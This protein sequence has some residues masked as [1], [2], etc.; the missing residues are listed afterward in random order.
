MLSVFKK[1]PY[2]TNQLKAEKSKLIFMGLVLF[3]Q[4]IMA[5][6]LPLPIRFVLDR[7]LVPSHEQDA[8]QLEY[9]YIMAGLMLLMTLIVVVL[10][11]YEEIL[12]S[13]AI[14]SL[15]NRVR[16]DLF[17][18]LLSRQQSYI[19]SKR[20]IDL[21]GR[22]SGDVA[23]L[24]IPIA[25]GMISLVRAVPTVIFIMA[26]VFWIQWR[27]ALFALI[28]LPTMY[29][30][31]TWLSKKIRANEKVMRSKTVIMDQDM[32][33]SLNSMALIKSLTGEEEAYAQIAKR[34]QE[35]ADAF[36]ESRR[37]Y[38]YFNSSLTGSRN[39]MRALFV[40]LGGLA[41]LSGLV[42]VGVLVLFIAYLE[43]L[44]RP[45][46]DISTLISRLSK[47][48]VSIERVEQLHTELLS[49]PESSGV[50]TVGDRSAL[51]RFDH[52]SF[53]Y[54]ESG[55]LFKDLSLE[56]P[57]GQ[58]IAVVGHSGVGK[59]SFLKL[60]NRLQDPSA[61]RIYLGETDL[62]D[63]DIHEL[64]K[65][66]CVVGQ[67]PLF[68]SASV[69]ENILMALPKNLS[70][71]KIQDA[72]G[73]TNSNEFVKAMPL[74]LDT[75]IGEAGVQISGGQAKRLS[76]A[77]G[78]LRE[79]QAGIFVFDEPTS[80]LDTLSA[81]HV[82]SAVQSLV[83]R[84]NLV[85]WTTHRLEEVKLADQVLYF[86]D[87]GPK[88]ASHQALFAEHASYRLLFREEENI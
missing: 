86:T 24:E 14:A 67:D 54:P 25:S 34:Q 69:R 83:S 20:K 11:Y 18:R 32:H 16:G 63:F 46:N 3:A 53:A 62:K 56:F 49:Y 71:E 87:E 35:V 50:K 76:L 73:Q 41:V 15:T 27:L 4:A 85:M 42:T 9:L 7:L 65:F 19:D 44:N 79:G 51:L 55:P 23:N 30:L 61:G 22:L 80:G 28:V 2:V 78:F 29:F 66:V 21:M 68:F 60:L 26:A 37:S 77:R 38:A 75:Q 1:H 72:L 88:L 43:A 36:Q 45:I 84:S 47:A 52:V 58:L 10:D 33:Q 82:I 13:K 31:A 81:Q 17:H 74:G 40:L 59:T 8:Q 57:H 6:L 5:L 70:N 12:T 39:L 48:L 64:R